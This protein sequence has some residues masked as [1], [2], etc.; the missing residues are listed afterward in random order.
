MALT[1]RTT[2]HPAYQDRVI[3]DAENGA[4]DVLGPL[5]QHGVVRHT[6]VGTLESTDMWFR[7]GAASTG[8]T[9]Y[10]V[11]IGGKIYMWNDPTGKA[12]SGVTAN[13]AG[14]ANG[15]SDGLEGDGV[16]FVRL[17]GV[18]AIN[19]WLVSIERD[20]QQR[21]YDYP[22][23]DPQALAIDRIIAYVFDQDD[24]PW[25]KYPFNPKLNCVTDFFHKEFATKGCPWAPVEEAIN[26]S[27]DRVR[28]FLKAAQTEINDEIPLP[29]PD[30]IEQDHDQLPMGY[31]VEGLTLHFGKMKR[32]KADGTK[33][34]PTGFNMKG[35]ISNAWVAR[36]AA[37]GRTME[38]LPPADEMAEI[39]NAKIILDGKTAT[40]SIVLFDGRG[41]DNW[42]LY[43]PDNSISWR[44]M[45]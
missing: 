33:L 10:G 37:E 18:N 17:H 31:T 40:A 35:S 3:P 25:D 2:K 45:I 27:Q 34:Q 12:R 23:Q 26:R 19:S 41:S 1:F 22:Y 4:W 9:T 42:V 44:W 43:R 6:M 32:R 5:K 28:G 16:L 30:P 8:L 36:G 13:R 29:P 39:T 7:R 14:W 21:P 20:D 15:G 11:G 24:V 38:Q